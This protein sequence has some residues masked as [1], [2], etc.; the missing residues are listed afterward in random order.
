MLLETFQWRLF[1]RRMAQGLLYRNH[2]H[3]LRLYQHCFHIQRNKK[4][5]EDI[6]LESRVSQNGDESMIRTIL[7]NVKPKMDILQFTWIIYNASHELYPKKFDHESL[8]S[9]S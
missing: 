1:E 6:H 8:N 5:I 9:G 7:I 4:Y 2:K 3:V